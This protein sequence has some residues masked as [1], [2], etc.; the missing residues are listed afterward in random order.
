MLASPRA[1]GQV[2]V[3]PRSGERIVVR[4]SGADTAGRLLVFDL[5]LPPGGHVPAAHVH[6]VQVEQFTILA[7]RLR[8]QIGRRQILAG[9]GETVRVPAG[10]AHWFGNAGS[11]T[12]EARVEVRPAL[13]MEELLQASAAMPTTSFRLGMRWPR[14]FKL[15]GFLL[16][17]HREIAVPNLPAWLVRAVLGLMVHIG[18]HRSLAR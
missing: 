10:K 6:P 7:G 5:W 16:E 3:N 11:G 13:R 1:G 4:V 8:F 14:P 18:R 2:I 17:F 12:A 15:A 9:P